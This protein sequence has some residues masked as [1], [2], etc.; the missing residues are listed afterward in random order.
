MTERLAGNTI[1]VLDAEDA[2]RARG[3]RAK[4]LREA[5]IAHPHRW[6]AQECATQRA[7]VGLRKAVWESLA[8]C[9]AIT[10]GNAAL[11]RYDPVQEGK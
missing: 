4:A 9:E 7:A 5:A 1:I 10:R 3:D 6:V 8:D 2:P 11:V